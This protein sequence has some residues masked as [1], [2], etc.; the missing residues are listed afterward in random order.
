MESI[1]ECGQRKS[2]VSK[3]ETLTLELVSDRVCIVDYSHYLSP[4]TVHVNYME[5]MVQMVDKWISSKF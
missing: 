1:V 4:T 5:A 3:C 2:I